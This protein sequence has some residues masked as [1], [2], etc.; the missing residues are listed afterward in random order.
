MS[1][2]LCGWWGHLRGRCVMGRRRPLPFTQVPDGTGPL[3]GGGSCA[4]G[5]DRKNCV[6][7]ILPSFLVRRPN[8]SLLPPNSMS[9]LSLPFCELVWPPSSLI[10][11]P[12]LSV[13]DSLCWS[14]TSVIA[15]PELSSVM[16]GAGQ[17]GTRDLTEASPGRRESTTG[18]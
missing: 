9:F 8:F 1:M 11:S 15:S 13:Q 12:N 5:N 4:E 6:I 16:A 10:F 18:Q 3:N 14:L 17:E 7:R 2:C